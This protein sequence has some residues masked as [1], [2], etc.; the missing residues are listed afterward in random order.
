KE[1]PILTIVT[2]TIKAGIPKKIPNFSADLVKRPAEKIKTAR[3]AKRMR[4]QIMSIALNFYN[5]F[6]KIV[7]AF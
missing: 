1:V 7:L 3:L 6:F 2:P 5:Y 4:I